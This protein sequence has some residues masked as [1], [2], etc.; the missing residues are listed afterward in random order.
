MTDTK[1]IQDAD[2]ETFLKPVEQGEQPSPE[3]RSW[4]NEQIQN[5]LDKKA[6]G[7][8]NYTPLEEVRKE[9]GF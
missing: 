4:M 6:R 5:T 3:H 8:M 2:L 1:H 7:E 9:F